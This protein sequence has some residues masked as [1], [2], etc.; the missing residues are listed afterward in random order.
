MR[1]PTPSQRGKKQR[2]QARNQVAKRVRL[3]AG[4]GGDRLTW[5]EVQS[6]LQ[7]E[8]PKTEHPV[9]LRHWYARNKFIVEVAR[10]D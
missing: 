8:W 6:K 3:I 5:E 4:F 2:E 9:D 7:E 10:K 1:K